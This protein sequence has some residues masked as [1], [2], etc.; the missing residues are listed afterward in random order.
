MKEHGILFSGPMVRAIRRK[1]NPKTQTWRILTPQPVP[2]SELGDEEY[3]GPQQFFVE[4][5]QLRTPLR[6]GSKLVPDKYQPGDRLRVGEAWRTFAEYDHLKPSELPDDAPIWYEEY[7]NGA[8]HGFGRYR[9]GRFLPFRFRRLTLE[10]VSVRVERLQE[11][12]GPDCWAEGIEMD[13]ERY[14][15]V[16][17][18]Y[19]DLWESING[20][21]SWDANPWVWV[22]EFR[23]LEAGEGL[24]S[25]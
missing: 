24:A 12:S 17:H 5:G 11:I 25:A 1:E 9:Q 18:C 6:Y 14:G 19:R 23:K 3:D 22:I 21:G 4:R 15:S 2:T 16:T 7:A 8:D 13:C 10:V 20:P